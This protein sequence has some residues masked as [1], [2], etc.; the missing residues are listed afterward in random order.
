MIVQDSCTA[1]LAGKINSVPIP[2]LFFRPG[3]FCC[4]L[5]LQMISPKFQ[6]CLWLFPLPGHATMLLLHT[7]VTIIRMG[8]VDPSLTVWLKLSHLFSYL[9]HPSSLSKVFW[10]IDIDLFTLI[11]TQ[12]GTMPSSAHGYICH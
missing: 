9:L 10:Y 12:Y 5:F 11:T 6:Q 2:V 8:A 7:D 1:I 3:L 4:P